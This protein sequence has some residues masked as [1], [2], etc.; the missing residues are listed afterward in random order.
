M[1]D[2]HDRPKIS[3][4]PISVLLPAYN[5]AAGLAAIANRWVA[6]LDRLDRPYELIL[7]D[8]ASTDGTGAI[9]DEFAA[10]KPAVRVLRHERRFGFGACLRTGVA[11]ARHP[12]VFYTACDYPYVPADLRKLLGVIDAADVAN[13]ARTDPMPARMRR[14]GAAYRLIVRVVLG[15]HLEPKPGWY[16]WPAWRRA[17]AL[18]CFFGLRTHDAESAYKLFRRSVFDRLPI[19]SD[20]PFAHAEI[21]AK[22]NFMGCLIAEEPVGRLAGA[23]RGA[24]EASPPG[25]SF[26]AEARRVFRDPAFAPP[27]PDV[28]PAD[29]TPAVPAPPA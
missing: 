6:E 19:Q 13:G 23:F 20:G 28:P 9:V 25:V 15:I 3:G 21:L 7:I 14:V 18:R 16:G 12:L 2:S 27:P 11:A 10:G 17:V 29:L 26:A 22:A 24:A 4:E 5:Q 8:D 1:N